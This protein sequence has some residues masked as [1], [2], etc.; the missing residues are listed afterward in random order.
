MSEETDW[1]AAYRELA[2][3]VGNLVAEDEGGEATP[4]YYRAQ[5][6]VGEVVSKYFSVEA[7]WEH[8]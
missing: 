2:A 5:E 3:A 7:F 4:N 1:R 6:K 8:R